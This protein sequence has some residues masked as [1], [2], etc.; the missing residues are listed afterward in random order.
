[1]GRIR[2]L[3]ELLDLGEGGQN[4][5]I[6][7]GSIPTHK[8]IFIDKLNN[9]IQGRRPRYWGLG[10]CESCRWTVIDSEMAVPI[11]VKL[12]GIIKCG[13]ENVLAKEFFKK[14]QI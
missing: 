11:W 9:L 2:D 1:M 13:W 4:V 10:E 7:F 14:T 5:D 3:G 6:I 12:S 8:E